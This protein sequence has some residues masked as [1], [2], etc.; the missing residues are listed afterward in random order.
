M[1][2]L[3]PVGQIIVAKVF[4]GHSVPVKEGEPVDRSSYP[5]MYSVY[6]NVDTKERTAMSEGMLYM[7][8]HKNNNVLVS[9][10]TMSGMS[11]FFIQ[12][13]AAPPKHTLV[14]GAAPEE[15]SGLSL[16]MN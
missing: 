9:S 8:W 15:D 2:V 12:R 14:L 1:L 11:V 3:L 10:C 7:K 13:D 16:T 6:R 4:V 5:K